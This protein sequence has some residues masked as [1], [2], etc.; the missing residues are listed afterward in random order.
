MQLRKLFHGKLKA[1]N[2]PEAGERALTGKPGVYWFE[3]GT[4]EEAK[5]TWTYAYGSELGTPGT[6]YCFVWEVLCSS[7]GVVSSSGG[8]AKDQ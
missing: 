8:A 6:L 1:S 2:S 7:E 3:K 5:K 4:K